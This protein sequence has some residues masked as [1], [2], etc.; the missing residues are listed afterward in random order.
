VVREL[1]TFI[2]SPPAYCGERGRASALI[3]KKDVTTEQ[4]YFDCSPNQTRQIKTKAGS[5]FGF[6]F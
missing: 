4:S 6:L 5:G 3:I 2:A 1:W